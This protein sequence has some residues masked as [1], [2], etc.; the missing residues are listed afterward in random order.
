QTAEKL[1]EP[2]DNTGLSDEIDDFSF[3]D[4]EF[5]T[6]D[7]IEDD[8]VPAPVQADTD[9]LASAQEQPAAVEPDSDEDSPESPD[10]IDDFSILESEFDA[11]D[12]IQDD[13]DLTV[14]AEASQQQ[15]VAFNDL[16]DDGLDSLLMDSGFTQDD[17]PGQEIEKNDAFGD[18]VDLSEIDEFF[19]L[20][21]V[22]DDFSKE[23]GE[24]V[25]AET[26]E[27]SVQ[28]E[29]DFLLPDFDITADTEISDMGS[30][31]GVKEDDLAGVF[32]DTSFLDEDDAVQ[33]FA[34]ETPDLKLD[35]D[36]TIFESQPKQTA[37]TAVNEIEDINMDPLE[38]EQ[39]EFKKQL[40]DA[41]SRVKKAKRF[42]Y[43]AL[44][45]G[46]V[47]LSAAAGLG[48]MTYSAKSEVSKLTEQVSALEASLAKNSEN[49]PNAEINAVMSS[50]AQLNQQV[51]G[52]VTELQGNAQF[53]VDLLNNK[54]PDLVAK[55]DMVSKALEVLQGKMG[56]EGKVPLEPLAAPPKIE[57]KHEPAPAKIE[58][59]SQEHVPGKEG[60]EHEHA[61][62]VKDKTA[63]EIAPTKD[64]AKQEAASVK[65]EPVPE[66]APV[67]VKVQPEAAPAKPVITP[68][69]IVKEEPVKAITKEVAPGKWGVNLVAFKQEWFAKSKAAEF[70]RL[71]VFAEVIP[72]YEKGATMYRLRA[73]GFRS[74][75]EALSNSDRIKKALNLD[76]VWVSDN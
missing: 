15:Q 51:Y 57:I 58:A 55:Q 3:L 41:E 22:S 5:N 32:G 72:V 29:D 11:S 24:G 64:R 26:E 14:D 52:F 36:D 68:K 28:D 62:E 75:A 20:D 59:A 10:E 35:D 16:Q 53:P 6:S 4:D 37:D 43:A 44:G 40:E 46:A 47:A 2:D 38:L 42:T 74:K 34:Q 1:S 56:I 70:A 25:P 18:D 54:V 9:S 71:G 60:A 66:A 67:K 63:H 13:E 50:V 49:N 73:G 8:E 17:V 65:V 23:T 76:S 19:Q 27:A 7:L 30:N 45:L 48:V 31:S 33:A 39:E 61:P 69:V 21:E 12:M